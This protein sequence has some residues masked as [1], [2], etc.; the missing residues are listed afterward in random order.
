MSGVKGY[1]ILIRRAMNI[2]KIVEWV[3]FVPRDEIFRG[4]ESFRDRRRERGQDPG[5]GTG[6]KSEEPMAP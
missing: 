5:E 4:S 1:N 2:G 3:V 6:E